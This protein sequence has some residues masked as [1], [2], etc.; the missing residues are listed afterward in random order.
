MNSRQ[1]KFLAWINYRVR[2]VL[3]DS[4]QLVGTLLAF[5]KHMNLVLCDTEE[6]TR[7]KSKKKEGGIDRER[8]RSLG[9]I[10]LRG[11]NIV[12]FSAESPPSTSNEMFDSKKEGDGK[13]QPINR[14]N[15]DK[16]NMNLVVGHGMSNSN[17]PDSVNNKIFGLNG[18]NGTN[19]T[20]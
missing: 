15:N 8:K 20:N 4:R 5:D 16:V 11:E 14:V 3:Q 19:G 18:N 12:S 17:I 9:M 7:F 13:T 6:F 1:S 10:I 2:V